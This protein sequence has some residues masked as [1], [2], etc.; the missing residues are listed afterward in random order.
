MASW[1]PTP[2]WALATWTVAVVPPGGCAVE[3]PK[4]ACW[5][6]ASAAP[7]L[8]VQVTLAAPAEYVA[9]QPAG[10]TRVSSVAPAGTGRVTVSSCQPAPDGPATAYWYWYS[11]VVFEKVTCG[12]TAAWALRSSVRATSVTA[13]VRPLLSV[14]IRC[15][16]CGP[17]VIGAP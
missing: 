14:A 1:T 3:K 8:A 12:V 15:S 5:A 17:A 2:V 9:V 11:C 7:A 6:V 16:T 13:E 10:V 4:V